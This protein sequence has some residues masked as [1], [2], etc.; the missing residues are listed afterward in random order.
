MQDRIPNLWLQGNNDAVRL[1]SI[2]IA[3]L[4][5]DER[6]ERIIEACRRIRRYAAQGPGAQE[7]VFTFMFEIWALVELKRY[8][9]AWRQLQLHDRIV[10]GGPLDYQRHQ[11]DPHRYPYELIHRHA[12]L[13]YYTGRWKL[14]CLLMEQGL[15]TWFKMSQHVSDNL[16]RN[17]L[18]IQRKPT[19]LVEISLEHFY[20]RLGKDLRDW[21][22]WNKFVHGFPAEQYRITG[23]TASE[24]MNDPR[25]AHE[26]V[27]RMRKH[28]SQ[29]ADSEPLPT[30]DDQRQ[31]KERSKQTHIRLQGL[32]PKLRKKK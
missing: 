10:H 32:F 22:Y 26:L 11:W 3:Q 6:H 8:A 23:I 13:L 18:A 21:P 29:Q 4:M 5:I 17:V 19:I 15:A 27:R 30:A 7:G 25:K 20:Q 14:G 9:T 16:Y 2:F 1:Y 31:G 28:S 24:M 12:P